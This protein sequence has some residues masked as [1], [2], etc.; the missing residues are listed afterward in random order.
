MAA[1]SH[2]ADR[3]VRKI[4]RRIGMVFEAD[5]EPMPSS[6]VADNGDETKCEIT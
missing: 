2:C 5:D 6:A 4:C 3:L 1:Q